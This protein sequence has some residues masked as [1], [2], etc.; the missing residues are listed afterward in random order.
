M[1]QSSKAAII[2]YSMSLLLVSAPCYAALNMRGNSSF[3]RVGPGANFVV[4][5]A[6]PAF[7]GKLIKDSGATVS[8][9]DITFADGILQHLNSKLLLNGIFDVTGAALELNGNKTIHAQNG[10]FVQSVSV[11][12]TGNRIEGQPLFASDVTLLNSSAQLT[13][14]LQRAV[15]KN[16]VLNGGTLDIDD[17]LYFLDA[18]TITGNGTVD[19]NGDRLSLGGKEFSWSSNNSWNK[20]SGI[21]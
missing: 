12:S 13:V 21:T 5:Q 15:N 4:D 14:A 17:N 6:I 7:N 11:S 8:G 3:I 10:L 18:K 1:K 20:A 16:I 19:L 9:Q 2:A